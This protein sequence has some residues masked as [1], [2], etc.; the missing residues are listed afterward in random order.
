MSEERLQKILSRAGVTSRRKAEEMILAGRVTVNGRVEAQ[1]GSKADLERDHIKV[2][3]KLLRAP[4][5]LV[6]IALNKPKGYVTT[7]DDPQG[8]PKVTDLLKGLKVRV[9]PVGR[10]DY[11]SE[12][13]VVL[14][15]DGDFA[16]R[17]M[18]T[19][20]GIEKRYLVKANGLLTD[21]QL[22]EFREGIPLGGRRTA[23]A[24]IRL[25]RKAQNPWYEVA[26]TEGR[27]HQVRLM[28]QHFGR[29]VEKLKRVRIG[30]LQLGSL[31][32]AA[33]RRLEPREVDAF[34]RL[35]RYQDEHGH[36]PGEEHRPHSLRPAASTA[37]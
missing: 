4:R 13:L 19:S 22:E 37:R 36:L 33:W 20:G 18:S 5:D 27:H 3:G 15:N 34:R 25:I 28:F 11:N 35:F 24:K 7:L 17:V 6:Y 1:L 2:D 23:P 14:T 26:L 9:Y 29:L 32:P 8:R 10:L 16:N 31:Q 12:G 21:E 30:P